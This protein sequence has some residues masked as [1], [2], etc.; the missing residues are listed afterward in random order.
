MSNI[1]TDHSEAKRLC[2]WKWWRLLCWSPVLSHPALY[3]V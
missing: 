3:G 2:W 1:R